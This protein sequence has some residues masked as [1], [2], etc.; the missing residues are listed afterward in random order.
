MWSTSTLQVT[1]VTVCTATLTL[2][3]PVYFAHR[4]YVYFS[5]DSQKIVLLKLHYL[6]V[7]IMETEC[8]SYKV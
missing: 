5:Y 2:K 7:V 8:I 3:T 1:A 4:I 6:T